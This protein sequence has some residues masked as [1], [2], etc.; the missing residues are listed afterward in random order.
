MLSN[1]F[2]RRKYRHPSHE[3][4]DSKVNN[5]FA[6][7]LFRTS[8]EQWPSLHHDLRAITYGPRMYR[9]FEMCKRVYVESTITLSIVQAC[10]FEVICI[11]I[12]DQKHLSQ[13][14]RFFVR[15]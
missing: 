1:E 7:C 10:I 15:M 6:I 5:C 4:E 8:N 2:E 13:A 9:L 11:A 3:T 12:I 14:V